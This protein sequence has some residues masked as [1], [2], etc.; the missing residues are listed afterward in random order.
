MVWGP[1]KRIRPQGGPPNRELQ[2]G[3]GM[4]FFPDL[5]GGS[6]GKTNFLLGALCD[7]CIWVFIPPN[8]F[9]RPL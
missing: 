6:P 2:G 7:G 4:L 5:L 8:S 1:E 9:F 3:G